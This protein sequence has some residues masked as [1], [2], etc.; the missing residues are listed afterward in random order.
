MLIPILW[1]MNK[2]NKVILKI[3]IFKENEESNF[4]INEKLKNLLLK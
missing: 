1:I 3:I 4:W 2:P